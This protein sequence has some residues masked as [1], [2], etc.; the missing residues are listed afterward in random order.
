M[1]TRLR[2]ALLSAVLAASAWFGTVPAAAQDLKFSVPLPLTGVLAFTGQ[3]QQAAWQHAVDYINRNGGIRG[4][5]I[6]LSLY[7]DEYKVDLGVAG[8]KKAVA[9]GDVVFAGG[10]GTPF[11]RAISPENNERYKV[12][13]SNTGM[14][15]DL[16]DTAKYPYHFLAAPN[17][18]DMFDMLFRYMKSKQGSGPAPKVA[19]VYSS[20]EF[21]RDPLENARKRA[22]A[23]GINVVLEDETKFS[24]VDIG[25]SAIK[26]RNAGADYVIFHGYAGGVWPEILKQSRQYGIK[27][28]FM[29]TAFGADPELVR[30]VGPAADGFLGVVP[31]TLI[32]KDNN[33]PMIKVID[34]Y[35]RSWK[36]KPYTGYANMSYMQ[37]W[38]TALILRDAIG[39]VIDAKKPLTGE[40][41]IAAVRAL[42]ASDFG[43]IYAEPIALAR[44]RIPA[45]VIYRYH[46]KADSFSATPEVPFVRAE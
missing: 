18:S 31:Y 41:L 32:V 10:D 5:K 14:A 11:I 22:A 42:K 27:S 39:N 35:L 12:L 37:I 1:A 9:N 38:V 40:N 8:F 3:I 26:L 28:Q 24:G 25:A 34:G 6:D 44:Q 16:V 33:A 20:T 15:S 19:F 13:M 30:G 43:G 36:G 23:L 46:V 2:L 17:Y 45:G 29:G 7:D 4:R 21:G